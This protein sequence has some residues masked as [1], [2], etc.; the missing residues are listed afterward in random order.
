MTT[1][2]IGP[3]RAR[4]VRREAAVKPGRTVVLFH[5]FGAPGDDLVGL[6]TLLDRA[7]GATF[8]FPEALHDLAELAGPFYGGARAWWMIDLARLEHAMRTGAVRDMTKEIPKGLAEARSAVFAMLAELPGH[9]VPTGDLV[10]GGFSQ[11]AMLA[12]DVA[13]H[14][15][16]PLAGLA[17]LS[18]TYI[19]ESEWAP[20]MAGRAGTRVFQS[21]GRADPLL[22]YSVAETLRD[23]LTTAGLDVEFR[24][25][26]GG[27]GIPEPTL[28]QL[29]AWLAGT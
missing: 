2:T 16:M 23:A 26:E 24:A 1:V 21:H 17:L 5:G 4:I 27:H 15:A 18:G 6:E 7:A 8:V 3:L 10:L 28:R 19:A 11:G 14:G 22:P 12:L 20:K 9:G 25:F 29:S 13:L